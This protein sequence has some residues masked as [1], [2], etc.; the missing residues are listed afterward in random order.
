MVVLPELDPPF[1]MMTWIT[2]AAPFTAHALSSRVAYAQVYYVIP[3]DIGL[4][5]GVAVWHRAHA[6]VNGRRTQRRPRPRGR[7]VPQPVMAGR[8]SQPSAGQ[9][10]RPEAGASANNPPEIGMRTRVRCAVTSRCSAYRQPPRACRACH[11][12]AACHLRS[13]PSR[14]QLNSKTLARASHPQR[15]RDSSLWSAC[16]SRDITS[17]A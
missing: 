4:G 12:G 3:G 2:T 9:E 7:I 13:L 8:A 10:R 11:D 14:P 6:A 16:S 5:G 1:R 15:L 17:S